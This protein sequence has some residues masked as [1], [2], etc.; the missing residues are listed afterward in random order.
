MENLSAG[1][2]DRLCKMYHAETPGRVINKARECFTD[3]LA[4]AV[5]GAGRYRDRNERFIHENR[6]EG[7]C[8]IIGMECTVDVRT[9]A[10]INA[11][12]AHFLELDDSHRVAMTHLGAPIFSALLGAAELYEASLEDVLKAAVIGYEAAIRLANAIQPG[13]KKRGFHVSGTCCAV[14][15]ALGVAFML[16]YCRD[17]LNSVLC[18]ACTSAAGLLGVVS[19]R[20]E[21]KPYNVSNAAM[22]GVNSALYGKL[23]RGTEDIL[24]HSQGFLHVMTDSCAPERLFDE[25][26][27]IE[28]IYQ[29]CYAA[30]RHCHAP[31]EAML[32]LKKEYAFTDADI[33]D[34]QVNVY[35]LAIKGHDHT[36]ITGVSS[37]KQSIPYGVAAACLYQD[38]GMN[39]F[40]DERVRDERILALTRRVRVVE[41][42]AL[43]ALVP[44]MRAAIVTVRLNDGRCFTER[45]NY[46][47]GEPENPITSE[48]LEDKFYSLLESAGID[49]ATGEQV[50]H[51]ISRHSSE[52]AE[53]LFQWI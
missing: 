25:G 48:E 19:G 26:Y 15:S 46:A 12:N 22:V 17:E 51:F 6:A 20:S 5:A 50:I 36:D 40:T 21:Q 49:R 43:T 35:D 37:A 18:A 47:K 16:G 53:G 13:H 24:G 4:V 31:M 23:F 2:I 38:C 29:K 8:H 28:T 42:K 10:M 52:K 34:I 30:C 32:T 33:D 41:D 1:F 11:F 9:A 14:G 44:G 27:A 3:Y 39:A 45:V 7:C